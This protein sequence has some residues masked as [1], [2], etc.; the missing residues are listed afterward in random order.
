[1][2]IEPFLVTSALDCVV[3]QR[4]ARRLCDRCKV[5]H[6]PDPSDLLAAGW[7]V[8]RLA[9]EPPTLY[10]AVG[11]SACGRTGYRGR[12]AIHE[13]MLVDGG[14]RAADRRSGLRPRIR[15]TSPFDQGMVTLRQDGLA[16]VEAGRTTLEEVSRVVA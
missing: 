8:S 7:D 16:K 2:G 5:P 14:H 11:C 12:L 10:R 9:D 13:V 3:A 4:L 6:Q 15:S 1:M